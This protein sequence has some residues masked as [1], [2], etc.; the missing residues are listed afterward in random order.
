VDWRRVR[1]GAEERR[2]DDRLEGGWLRERDGE[3]RKD[4]LR[5]RP[6][7]LRASA[8]NDPAPHSTPDSWGIQRR[9]SHCH[10]PN[11]A[12]SRIRGECIMGDRGIQ[13]IR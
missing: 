12:R 4:P 1:W 11:V 8:T 9:S 13:V 10:H 5:L 6:P 7:L 3:E 2:W